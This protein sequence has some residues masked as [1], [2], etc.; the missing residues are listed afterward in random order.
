V[1]RS[2]IAG[3]TNFTM[4]VLDRKADIV[5]GG[6]CRFEAKLP[7][8]WELT[9]GNAEQERRF[10]VLPGAPADLVALDPSE[11][12]GLAPVLTISGRII[13]SAGQRPI[14][15]TAISPDGDT[16][17]L[18]LGEDG[19]F[20]FNAGPGRWVVAVDDGRAAPIRR[21]VEV[22]DTPV[23]LSAIGQDGP[24]PDGAPAAT[25]VTFDD[26]I[27]TRAVAEVPS[28]VAGV[29]WSNWVVAHNLNYGGEGYVNGTMSGEYVVYNSSGHPAEIH[30]EEAFDFLGGYFAIAWS[31]AEGESLRVTG[32]RGDQMVYQDEI[33]LSALGAVY[34]SA[35]YR[36]VT[37]VQFSTEHYWQ[38]VVDDVALGVRN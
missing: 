1:R 22:R 36:N 23:L 37:R 32:W 11:P 16:R 8:G 35:E 19:R 9:T 33:K 25:I 24:A 14:S 7:F 13:S 6:R 17:R 28:G 20:A 12:I 2:N 38:F 10:Q 26:L 27:G 29:G 30:D 4:S 15:L 3:F 5:N 34:F 31:R 21:V 18:E